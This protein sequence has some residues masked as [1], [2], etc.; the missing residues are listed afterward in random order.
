MNTGICVDYVSHMGDDLTV[1]NAARVSLAKETSSLRDRDKSLLRFLAENGH[2]SPFGHPQVTF[3][4]HAPIFV[5]RQLMRH[6][7][8]LHIN[9][10]SRRYT[11]GG[12]AFYEPEVWR[13]RPTTRMAPVDQA[14][15]PWWAAEADTTLS[16][17][18]AAAEDRYNE[19]I[20]LGVAPEQ[21]RMVLPQG[22]MTTW[23]WTGSLAAFAR[24]YRLRAT[25][26]AQQD[27]AGVALQIGDHMRRLFP[28]S[29]P[30][31]TE[32]T[33]A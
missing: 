17:A 21:A 11:E 12:L 28:L 9:E 6:K 1:V 22:L 20:E 5:A 15:D 13:K 16:A 24:V 33:E 30:L 26:E 23:Y 8:G 14:L 29:W 32:G 7:E 31:L 18:Y 2:W 25:P 4:V 27:T 3:R 10:L 19:L